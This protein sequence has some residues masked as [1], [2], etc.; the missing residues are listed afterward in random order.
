MVFF[1]AELRINFWT[2]RSSSCGKAGLALAQ[3]R[4]CLP[5]KM[6]LFGR[7]PSQLSCK[8]NQSVWGA[9][10]FL[11]G[12][13]SYST[14]AIAEGAGLETIDNA[15][16]TILFDHGVIALCSCF[17]ER[18]RLCFGRLGVTPRSP[19]TG[20]T[21]LLCYRAE[22][23]SIS[24]DLQHSTYLRWAPWLLFRYLFPPLNGKKNL[25]RW[26]LPQPRSSAVG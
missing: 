13:G 19:F 25:Q 1:L 3:Q 14:P 10:E 20:T 8:P 6:F 18:S 15:T 16:T 23:R 7:R 17:M 12:E 24:N 4:L 5:L 9:K 21:R 22:S 26:K 11:V 2:T